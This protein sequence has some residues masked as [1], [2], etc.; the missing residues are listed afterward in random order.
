MLATGSLT[1]LAL[2]TGVPLLI[3]PGGVAAYCLAWGWPGLFNLAVVRSNPGAPG[4]AT[5]I[6]QT[7]TY[8]GAVLGPLLFGFGVE[9]WSYSW[10]WFGSAITSALAALAV[11]N[12]RRALRAERD[13]RVASLDDA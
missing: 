2:A 8:I 1:N 13:G 12:A 3:V 11:F 5:G 6:T 7:G 4:A 9:A 10:A